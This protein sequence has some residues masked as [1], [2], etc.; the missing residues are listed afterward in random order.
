[1][2]SQTTPT[3]W[4]KRTL[5]KESEPE[6]FVPRSYSVETPGNKNYSCPSVFWDEVNLV[7][8]KLLSH[9]GGNQ[10]S[11]SDRKPLS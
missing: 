9:F 11:T 1:M 7:G 3:P 4:R 6:C 5:L 8:S 10:P 2:Y